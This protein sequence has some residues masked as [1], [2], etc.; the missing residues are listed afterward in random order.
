MTSQNGTDQYLQ[1]VYCFQLHTYIYDM[2]RFRTQ[3]FKIDLREDF[4]KNRFS[5]GLL[6]E[7]ITGE[8]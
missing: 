2:R 1:Y 8:N 7:V 5:L 4:E 6:V 3:N